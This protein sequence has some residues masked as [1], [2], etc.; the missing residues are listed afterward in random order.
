MK[1]KYG[2]E[3]IEVNIPFNSNDGTDSICQR[4]LNVSGVLLLLA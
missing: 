3:W 1:Q 4:G 2:H